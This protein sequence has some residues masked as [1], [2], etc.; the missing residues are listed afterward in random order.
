MRGQIKAPWSLEEEAAVGASVLMLNP[1]RR[2]QIGPR[3]EDRILRGTPTSALAKQIRAV[4]FAGQAIAAKDVP[5]VLE[6]LLRAAKNYGLVEEVASPIGGMGWRLIAKTVH[7]RLQTGG[8]EGERVERGETERSLD[9]REHESANREGADHEQHLGCDEQF[10]SIEP[11]RKGAA[12]QPEQQ[13]TN[14]A[15][16]TDQGDENQPDVTRRAFLNPQNLRE[17]LQ[18]HEHLPDGESDEKQS[19]LAILE[20]RDAD[21]AQWIHIVDHKR[22]DKLQRDLRGF[23]K[24]TGDFAHLDDCKGAGYA[25]QTSIYQYILERDYGMTIGIR[26][27]SK[28]MPMIAEGV[29]HPPMAI[30]EYLDRPAKSFEGRM[31][32]IPNLETLPFQPETAGV[33]GFY[34]R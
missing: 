22:S 16:G 6:A 14:P 31:T 9:A 29:E 32:A 3:D 25:L 2:A 24:M 4:K 21:G 34:S 30:P 1:P 27:R 11:I 17:E 33:I 12:I 7:Y 20:G 23:G 15:R 10:A 5:D 13:R 28:K 19:E 18:R 8:Q 26:E